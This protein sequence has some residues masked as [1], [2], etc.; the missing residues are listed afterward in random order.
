MPHN[1]SPEEIDKFAQMAAQWWDPQGP[2][3]PLHALNP[4][5]LA[6]IQRYTTLHG[7]KALDVGCGGGILTESLAANGAKTTGIDMSAAVLQVAQLHSLESGLT[8]HYQETTVED[9]AKHHAGTFSVVSC[10]EMLEHVPDPQSVVNACA[11]LT[12]PNGYV[13]FSTINRNPMAYLQAVIGAEYI[14]Q[15]LPR[16]THDYQKFIKPAELAQWLR[17]AGLEM[18]DMAGIR[19]NPLTQQFSLTD[20]T[21]VNYL[22]CAKKI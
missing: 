11:E 14:L 21:Q 13:F 12:A 16:G 1:V 18:V 5:R 4:L 22:L 8:I 9:F 19:Y 6:F 17:E 20:N 7:Q 10:M 15:L 3:Q 2:C